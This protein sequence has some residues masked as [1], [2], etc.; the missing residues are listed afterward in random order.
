MA[1]WTESC[2]KSLLERA[3]CLSQ[4]VYV[5]SL[6]MTKVWWSGICYSSALQCSC[7]RPTAASFSFFYSF[8]AA[9]G[10]ARP[11]SPWFDLSSMEKG[12]SRSKCRG[13]AFCFAP[14]A[15]ATSR[16]CNTNSLAFKIRKA[17]NVLIVRALR[18][19]KRMW[20]SYNY[21]TL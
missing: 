21:C 11:R 14:R 9:A 13:G 5:W 18:S 1:F 12:L 15:H 4:Y 19:T 2:R 3:V 20:N 17:Q 7:V 10:P 16:N 6:N 8:A